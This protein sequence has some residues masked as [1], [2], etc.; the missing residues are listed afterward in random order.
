M[1]FLSKWALERGFLSYINE[2][3]HRVLVNVRT[4]LEQHYNSEGN[5]DRITQSPRAWRE[6]FIRGV[7]KRGDKFRPPAMPIPPPPTEN[8]IDRKVLK[9]HGG[10]LHRIRLLN[11]ERQLLIGHEKA[12]A[13]AI[14]LELKN[15]DSIIGYLSVN[16]TS[17]IRDELGLS[18]TK[19]LIRTI[20]YSAIGILLISLLTA[21]LLA[22]GFVNPIK[23]LAKGTRALAAGNFNTRFTVNTKDEIGQLAKECNILAS[24]LESNEQSRKQWMADISHELRTPL[25]VLRG[26]IEA[27]KDGVRE[28]STK[29]IESLHL[30]VLHIQNIVNDLYELSMSDVGALS[31]KKVETDI[32]RIIEEVIDIYKD[33]FRKNSIEIEFVKKPTESFQIFADPNRLHQLI[34]NLL[35]NTLSYTD[36]GGKLLIEV[37]QND[38]EVCINFHDTNPGVAEKDIPKLFE[39]LYRVDNSRNR[40]F[41]G[42]GLGLSI[43]KNIVDAHQ[44][45]IQAY[46]SDLGGLH[47]KVVLPKSLETNVA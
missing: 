37:L 17:E 8:Q 16:R 12:N 38:A 41:G 5:W 28:V 40:K 30:E 23:E 42:T 43:C 25:T 9:I 21:Y 35:A 22:K 14:T 18:F 3:E 7:R 13:N 24:T 32:C 19:Q 6:F 29:T 39:R 26:E 36:K 11:A 45:T 33:D 4:E 46:Q 1:V 20:Q 31:Y 2:N 44:G 34:N 47:V 27:I 15:N 10:M